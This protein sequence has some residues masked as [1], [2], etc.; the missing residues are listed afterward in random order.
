MD[1]IAGGVPHLTARDTSF[2]A[3]ARAPIAKIE[4]FPWGLSF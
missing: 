4:A 1:N 2:A 3:I